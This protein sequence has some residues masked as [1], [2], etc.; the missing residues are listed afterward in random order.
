MKK[1]LI[2]TSI[3]LLL[4]LAVD[5]L[6]IVESFIAGGDS[7]SQSIGFTEGVINAIETIFPG[8]TS[9]ANHAIVHSIIR[10]LVGHFLLFGLSG[11]FT[12]L[13]LLNFENAIK[14]NKIQILL[15]G[16]FKGLIVACCSELIQYYTPGRAGQLTDILIDY[17]GYLLFFLIVYFVYLLVYLNKKKKSSQ[18]I[19]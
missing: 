5:T 19:S 6:I 4:F 1:Y 10:K 12:A 9:G 2:T 11:I 15:I 17:S 3:F 18:D 16:L 8:S 13:G 14:D 7:A